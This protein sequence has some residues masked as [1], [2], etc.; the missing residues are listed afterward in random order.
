MRQKLRVLAPQIGKFAVI[1]VGSTLLYLVIFAAMRSST[2]NQW[3]NIAALLASTVFNTA[4]NRRFTFE[5]KGRGGAA[6]VQLQS[7]ALLAITVATTAGGL[8]ILRQ[9]DPQADG[10][11]ST[12]TVA[13]GN[14]IATVVRFA[15]LRRWLAPTREDV[16]AAETSPTSW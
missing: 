10:L 16:V 14:V 1:G 3:A 9:V 4:L 5:V 13:V 15:L 2:G 7:L 6:R 8:E 11:V 12:G